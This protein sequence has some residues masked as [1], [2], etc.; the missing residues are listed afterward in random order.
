MDFEKSI[1]IHKMKKDT[2]PIIYWT[3]ILFTNFLITFRH[4]RYAK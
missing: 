4:Y 3:I 2:L 1:D